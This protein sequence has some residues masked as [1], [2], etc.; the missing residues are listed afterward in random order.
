MTNEQDN[1]LA[2]A[3]LGDLHKN[4]GWLMAG[5]ILLIILGVV[6]MSMSFTMTLATMLYF[7]I[8]AIAAAVVML[9]DTFKAEGWKS[10]VWNLLISVLYGIAGVVMIF[11]PAG[12]A[13]W[14]TLFMV[15]F[16]FTV[17]VMRII[18]G[19][20]MRGISGWW[21]TVLA[22]ISAIILSLMIF[23]KWPVSGLWAIG[24]FVSVDL[25]MQ[26]ISWFSLAWAAKDV[27][28]QLLP[29]A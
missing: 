15:G 27:N 12:S 14:F 25:L 22:G 16:L 6:G 26:G 9:I 4:W 11:N 1:A 3:L 24:L 5:G 13:I 29:E 20:Q 23:V 8:L 2:I 18:A 17:G 10:K 7:G 28:P 19:F 21:W